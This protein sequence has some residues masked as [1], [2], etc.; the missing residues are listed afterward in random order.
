MSVT[1]KV[2]NSTTIELSIEAVKALD[3]F[4]EA[5]KAEA[6]AKK[7]KAEAEAIL[8]AELGNA[9]EAT[10]AGR[11]ALK[12]V[13]SKNTHINKEALLEAFPEAYEATLV[14]TPYTYLKNL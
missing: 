11:I 5:K 2:S 7:A 1:T 13:P 10:I 8:R 9:V 3:A 14:V 12:V 4:A 6:Q